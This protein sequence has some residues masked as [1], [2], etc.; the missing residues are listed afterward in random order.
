GFEL[1]EARTRFT[2]PPWR[3]FHFTDADD[4]GFTRYPLPGEAHNEYWKDN[5]VFGHFIKTVV[6]KGEN[7]PPS[8]KNVEKRAIAYEGEPKT[9]WIRAWF[10]SYALPYAGALVLLFVAVF[11]LRKALVVLSNPGLET[12]KCLALSH[13][14]GVTLLLAG[15]TVLARIVRLTRS[16]FW[17]GF[18]LVFFIACLMS[19]RLL[20]CE[21]S[22]LCCSACNWPNQLGQCWAWGKPPLFSLGL[23]SLAI[24]VGLFAVFFSVLAGGLRRPNWGMRTLLIPAAT[25]LALYL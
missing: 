22:P 2:A 15:L 4:F 25:G 14:V 10:P 7:M 8:G 11:T 17:W 23:V 21:Q 12:A 9:K 18:G 24:W 13:C 1:D 16:L 5:D 19:Y 20:I 3:A 6:Y